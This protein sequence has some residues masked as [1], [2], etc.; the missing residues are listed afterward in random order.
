MDKNI[1]KY[2]LAP[3]IL[4]LA[5]C[6][7][8]RVIPQGESR[9][10]HNEIKIL[11]SKGFEAS[12]I[13]P[14]IKQNPNTYF[15]L[16][17]NPFLNI[18]NWSNGKDNGWNR[19]VKKVGQ[20]PVIFDKELVAS[21]VSNIENHLKYQ[22]YY[23]SEVTDSIET[24]NKK[25]SVTYF[26]KL[27]K[28]YTIDSTKYIIDDHLL[29]KDFY[30]DS[31]Q[32]TIKAGDPL[33]ENFLNEASEKIAL[34]LRNKGY[35]GF[36]KNYLFFTADTL[37]GNGKAKLTIEIKN[38][39]RNELP[40]DARAHRIFHYGK[41]TMHPVRKPS[42]P[43][44]Y[45]FEGDSVIAVPA[46][47]FNTPTDSLTYRGIEFKYRNKLI[48]RK[49]VLAR[50]NY[51]TPGNIYKTIKSEHFQQCK[52]TDGPEGQQYGRLQHEAHCIRAA[53]IQARS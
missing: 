49:S 25:T 9:L 19:F 39:T 38:Y 17:W 26:I 21:S 18:Y 40:K 20:E 10:A 37:A 27:G 52:H 53:G 31:L 4:I 2:L 7:T 32:K 42:N 48:L 43:L 33:S 23:N 6:S 46:M 45:S 15:L 5:G 8:T 11:N 13:E 29:E 22:G 41:V 16:G 30:T 1:L 50:M 36:S 3:M 34:A 14:Y 51:V 24:K 47:N 35:Y 12:G 28:R 44:I